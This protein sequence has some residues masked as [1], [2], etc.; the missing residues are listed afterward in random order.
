M[1]ILFCSYAYPNPWQPGLGTF[2]RTMLAGLAKQ[3]LVRV[4]APVAFTERWRKPGLTGFQAA[5]N[6]SAEYPTYF[7]PPKIGRSH[8]DKFLWWSIRR[9]V[10]KQIRDFQPDV[11]LSYW[12]H[13][14]GAVAVRAAHEAGLPAVVMV[15]GSDVL[16]LARSGSRR[17]AI[18]NALSA[19]DAVVAVSGDLADTLIRDGIPSEKISVIGRGIDPTVFHP[20]DQSAARQEWGL[21][22]NRPVIVGVGRLV[23]VKDWTTWVHACGQLVTRGLNPACYVCG[24]G[25]LEAELR[26]L[27]ARNGW[28]D[29]IELRGSQSP[30]ELARW[31]RAADVTLLTS[32]SEGIPNVLL[33]SMACGG[34]FVATAVG[35]IPEIADPVF[36]RLAPARNATRIADALL[37]RLRLNPPAGYQRRFEPN[38]Q[39]TTM[40]RLTEL[41]SS[42]VQR[43][44]STSRSALATGSSAKRPDASAC[45]LMNETH[46]NALGE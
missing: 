19:A 1:R 25:P 23:E 12:A 32:V 39:T 42:V 41:F 33:E 17:R 18:L 30:Q 7:Y 28:N 26:R 3:H 34:S 45:R 46:R 2:N 22:Q 4:I 10:R 38:S 37:D 24:A 40:H 35:G 43:H 15:G 27:I 14:D 31:Y 6:I 29:F 13:P 5:A 44:N 21:P 9:T 8:Y 20:G 36:D 16:L 11:V